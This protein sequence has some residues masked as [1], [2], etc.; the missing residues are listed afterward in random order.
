MK[1]LPDDGLCTRP[2]YVALLIHNEDVV[3]LDG[4]KYEIFLEMQQHNEMLL[5]RLQKLHY[6]I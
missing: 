5:P 4:R 1:I 6:E 3:M 2:K